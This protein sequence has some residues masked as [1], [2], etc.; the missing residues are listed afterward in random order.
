MMRSLIEAESIR[1]QSLLILSS[2]SRW[3]MTVQG[4]L[5]EFE[6]GFAPDRLP[7]GFFAAHPST[8]AQVIRLDPVENEHARLALDSVVRCFPLRFSLRGKDGDYLGKPDVVAVLSEFT[9]LEGTTDRLISCTSLKLGPG[10]VAV[11]PIVG[12]FYGLQAV[13]ALTKE[14]CLK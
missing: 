12:A 10:S 4:T 9:S 11:A 2:D 3:G 8:V 5:V 7:A 14:D 13:S 6:K 1:G